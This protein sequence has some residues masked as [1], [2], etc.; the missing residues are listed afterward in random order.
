MTDLDLD[1]AGTEEEKRQ[2]AERKSSHVWRGLRLASKKQ[3]SSFDKIEHGRGLEALQ[4]VTAATEVTGDGNVPT[5]PDDQS[6]DPH[7]DKREK[8]EELRADQGDQVTAA[9]IASR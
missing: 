5:S 1:M 9:D 6:Q 8:A 4:P 3:L 2:V 7:H